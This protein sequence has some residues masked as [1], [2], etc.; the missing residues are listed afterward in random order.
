MNGL[1]VQSV[2]KLSVKIGV[3]C[4]IIVWISIEIVV[5]LVLQ[6]TL[7][8]TK[9]AV[10][11]DLVRLS[12][13]SASVLSGDLHLRACSDAPDAAQAFEKFRHQMQILRS[14]ADF[15][16]HWYTLLPRSGDTVTF[17]VMTHQKPFSGDVHIF[18]DS[19][20]AAIFRDALHSKHP[21]ATD[22]YRDDNG[23]WISGFAPIL[24]STGR[25]AAVLELDLTYNDY[26]KRED[27]IHAQIGLVRWIGFVLGGLLGMLVGWL[28]AKPVRIASEAVNQIAEHDFEGNVKLPV[29]LQYFPDETAALIVNVNKMAFKLGEAMA[30]LREANERLQSLDQAKSVFLSFVAHELRTPLSALFA[31]KVLELNPDLDDSELELLHA[32]LSNVERLRAFS[33]AAEQYVAALTHTPQFGEQWSLEEIVP[34]LL[35][36]FETSLTANNIEFE[37]IPPEHET[38]PSEQALFVQ[39]PYKVLF[40]ILSELFENAVKFGAS[41]SKVVVRLW[42]EDDIAYCTVQDFGVGFAPE[43][44]ERIFEPFFVEI[45]EHHTQGVGVNLATARVYARQYNGDITAH[46]TGKDQG[47]TFTV[48][49]ALVPSSLA[50]PLPLASTTSDSPTFKDVATTPA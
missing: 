33:I 49:F 37:Y 29:S 46:S 12:S 6:Q 17:G 13:V 42:S 9:D 48:R 34:N 35:E 5:R 22:L 18:R 21:E 26:A 36:D 20:V 19:T 32:A 1:L 4:A 38:Q 7:N 27:E 28:V 47:C 24:D 43:L 8:A 44:G 40:T 50:A 14:A 31:L 39:M 45:I 16:E 25:V 23:V 11:S 41:G 15:R 3:S 30:E 2:R 10:Q